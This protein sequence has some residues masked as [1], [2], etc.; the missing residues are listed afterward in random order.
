MKIRLLAKSNVS[1]LQRNVTEANS[2]EMIAKMNE[3]W[4]TSDEMKC[5]TSAQE[6]KRRN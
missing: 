6:S 1:H 2:L 5:F 4:A 3:S